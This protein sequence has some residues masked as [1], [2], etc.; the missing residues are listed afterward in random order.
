MKKVLFIV[1]HFPPIGGA[2]AQRTLNFIRYLPDNGYLPMVVTG[3]GTSHSRWTPHDPSLSELISPHIQIC[4]V[5]TPIPQQRQKLFSRVERWLFALSPFSKWWIRSAIDAAKKA[6]TTEGADLIYASMSPFES[7]NVAAFLSRKFRVPWVADLRDAW[8]LDEIQVYPSFIH[9]KAE[10][11]KMH[12][13][14][15]TASVIIMNTPEATERLK[16]TFPDFCKKQIVTITNGFNP[17][18]FK[19]KIL[20]RTENKFRIVHSGSFL[21]DLGVNHGFK[22]YFREALGGAIKGVDMSTR[23]P[24]VLL[25]A[26]DRC[27]TR[28]TDVVNNLE[29]VFAGNVS[30]AEL[31]SVR[32]FSVCNSINFIGYVPRTKSLELVRTADLLFIAMHNLPHGMR[33]TSIPSKVYEYMA[34]GCPILAAVPDGAARDF[35]A[36]SRS[37]FLCR[38]DDIECMIRSIMEA[39]SV[40][41]DKKKITSV[42]KNFLKNFDRKILTKALA[43]EFDKLISKKSS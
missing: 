27:C 26:L 24:F 32:N 34:S 25:E 29:V 39:Y 16:S 2:P 15:S 30:K 19:E 11:V 35:L 5:Q 1:Y 13:L 10:L 22:K 41:K 20:P 7:A 37:A 3:P 21:T 4:R 23:S 17:S 38:P 14:L 43:T 9:R 42:N 12:R 28:H 31:S 36:Q 8:G 18:D 6:L 40:W 33:S